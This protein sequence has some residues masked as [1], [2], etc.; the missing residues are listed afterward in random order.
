MR[1]GLL[2][3]VVLILALM[4]IVL[5]SRSME[6][7]VSALNS[8]ITRIFKTTFPGIKTIVDPV[9]QMRVKIEE[10]KKKIQHFLEELTGRSGILI[11]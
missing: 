5:D 7:K 9:Q 3:G 1:T 8:Q 11:F 6:K 2:F 10:L 4:S